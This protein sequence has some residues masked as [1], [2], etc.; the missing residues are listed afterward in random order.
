MTVLAMEVLRFFMA[1]EIQKE[2]RIWP[3]FLLVGGEREW[4]QVGILMADYL[5]MDQ[6]VNVEY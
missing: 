3:E 5:Q 4:G 6:L 2:K 1:E